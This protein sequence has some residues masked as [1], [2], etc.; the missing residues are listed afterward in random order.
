[1]KGRKLTWDELAN[2]YDKYHTGRP[3]RTL[4]MD[5]VWDWAS[6]KKNLFFVDKDETICL[7]EEEDYDS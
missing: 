1:M 5:Y 2:Y 3:A 6:K 4:P 7:K